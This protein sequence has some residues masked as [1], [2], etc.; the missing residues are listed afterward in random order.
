V[1]PVRSDTS[2]KVVNPEMEC[3]TIRA[4]L[5]EGQIHPGKNREELVPF[6]LS[7]TPGDAS[8]P[9]MIPA[10]EYRTDVVVMVAHTFS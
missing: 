10:L 9:E 1:K 7:T 3:Q 2:D 6:H 8:A 4:I 5:D